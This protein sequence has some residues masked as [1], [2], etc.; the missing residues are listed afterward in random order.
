MLADKLGLAEMLPL[1]KILVES[2]KVVGLAVNI[3]QM[4]GMLRSIV[5]R[6]VDQR[7]RARWAVLL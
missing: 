4:L 6:F 5:V 1:L 7:H 3:L 2:F